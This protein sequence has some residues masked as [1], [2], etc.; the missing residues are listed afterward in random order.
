MLYNNDTSGFEKLVADIHSEC[1]NIFSCKLNDYGAVWLL[2]RDVSMADQLWIKIRR[3]RTLE[4]TDGL[5][6][7]DEGRDT[8]FI[9]IINYS[10]MMLMKN[11]FPDKYPSSDTV[12]GDTS[13]IDRIEH[14]EAVADYN[15]LWDEV[16]YLMRKKNRDY[17][18]AWTEMHTFSITDQIITK[19]HR[20]KNII[21]NN[22]RLLISEN[23]DAQLSD[24]INYS[25]FG[26]ILAR[27]LISPKETC[28]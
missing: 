13:I 2:F 5:P 16:L 11:R 23:I 14:D 25:I 22:G 8:E 27:G 17:G 20:V 9:G 10:F 19:I 3:I 18:A 24:I 4:Q 26:L 6:S 7:V 1:G 21:K 12:V 28:L 15:A